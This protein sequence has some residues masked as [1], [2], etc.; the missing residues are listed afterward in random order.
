M[1][2]VGEGEASRIEGG[3]GSD[4]V[5]GSYA[6]YEGQRVRMGLD[7]GGCWDVEAIFGW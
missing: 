3:M 6:D 2:Y 7:G 1:G 5:V 4:E